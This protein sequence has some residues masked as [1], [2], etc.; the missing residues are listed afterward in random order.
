MNQWTGFWMMVIL[1][2]FHVSERTGGEG[3]GWGLWGV[4]PKKTKQDLDSM[5]IHFRLKIEKMVYGSMHSRMD[6]VKIVI[7]SL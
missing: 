2:T 4:Q 6:Q 3:V 1:N 5:W 7:D